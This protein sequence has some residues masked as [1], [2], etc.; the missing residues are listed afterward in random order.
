MAQWVCFC[1]FFGFLFLFINVYYFY[2][3]VVCLKN[4]CMFLYL[5]ALRVVFFFVWMFCFFGGGCVQCCLMTLPLMQM[6]R[7]FLRLVCG[8]APC[9]LF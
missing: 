5:L 9:V 8:C 1:C 7:L 6:Y 4:C 3:Y 2:A